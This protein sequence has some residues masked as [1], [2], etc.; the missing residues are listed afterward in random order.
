MVRGGKK[1]TPSAKASDDDDDDDKS[2][3]ESNA[4]HNDADETEDQNLVPPHW[5]S[6][7]YFKI[8]FVGSADVSTLIEKYNIKF[9]YRIFPLRRNVPELFLD[10]SRSH[11]GPQATAI[12]DIIGS[13]LKL[14]GETEIPFKYLGLCS[15]FNG[16]D[17]QQTRTHHVSL[18]VSNYIL[19][20]VLQKYSCC[21][22]YTSP[23]PRD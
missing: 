11:C 9:G 20:R 2:P 14:P 4:E 1:K 21:L 17:V 23:S 10:E 12:F 15:D 22:L 13:Q 16:V 6:F 18:N 19:R 5:S 8:H 3:E 7:R